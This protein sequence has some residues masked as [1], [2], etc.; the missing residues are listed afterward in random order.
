M[1]VSDFLGDLGVEVGSGGARIG[2][3]ALPLVLFLVGSAIAGAI[4][5]WWA[6]KKSYNKSIHIFTEVNGMTVPDSQDMAREIVLPFT[7][8]R[9]FYLRKL[10]IYLPRPSIS[11]GKDH[12]WFYV[13]ADGEW[14]NFTLTSLDQELKRLKLRFDHTDMR[15]ANASLKKLV[16]KSYKKTNWLKEYAPYIG[17][18]ILILMLGIVAF[19]VVGEAGKITGSLGGIADNLAKT[20]EEVA[21]LLSGVDNIRSGSGIRS[22]G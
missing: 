2:D 18:A 10:K 12:Y 9:A 7:S 1:A 17:M 8:V 21:N 14:L 16:E 4:A 13:R 11:T 6:N 22:A 3:F 20:T 5:W 19:L 15:M